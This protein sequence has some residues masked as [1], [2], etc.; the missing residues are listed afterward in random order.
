MSLSAG[1]RCV[2]KGATGWK[3]EEEEAAGRER[4]R[5]VVDVKR[6]WEHPPL[7]QTAI[8]APRGEYLRE[9]AASGH[10]TCS[11]GITFGIWNSQLDIRD[12]R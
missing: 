5:V 10:K 2:R 9:D 3:E 1:T 8:S 11:F 6:L 12:T 7:V 4:E